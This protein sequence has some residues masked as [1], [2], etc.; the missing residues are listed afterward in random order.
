MQEYL[1]TMH[2][3]HR[4]KSGHVRVVRECQK[5]PNE[6][7]IRLLKRVNKEVGY[8]YTFRG[9]DY[10]GRPYTQYERKD[11]KLSNTAYDVVF[12]VK[13]TKLF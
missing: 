5:N 6:R 1:V 11:E 10:W 3:I 7:Q 2:E 13:F 4:Y 9:K 8:K 12:R